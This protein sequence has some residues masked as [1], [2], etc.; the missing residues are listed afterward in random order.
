MINLIDL[1]QETVTIM[2]NTN[3]SISNCRE[4][5]IC[6]L[7]NQVLLVLRGAKQKEMNLKINL[8]NVFSW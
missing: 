3:K 2:R 8:I 7:V 6:L 5:L 1:L 4:V